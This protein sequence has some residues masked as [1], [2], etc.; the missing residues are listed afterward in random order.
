MTERQDR[1]AQAREEIA[2]RVANF[3]VT[4]E[5]FQ[6]EREEYFVTTMKNAR[7]ETSARGSGPRRFSFSAKPAFRPPVFSRPKANKKKPGGNAPGFS[8]YP[9]SD[10]ASSGA[11][12]MD[13]RNRHTARIGRPVVRGRNSHSPAHNTVR[14]AAAAPAAIAPAARPKAN[15]GPRPRAS[16]GAATVVAPTVAT[17]AKIRM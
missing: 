15:P 17:V 16:A 11:D 2:M 14:T 6:R 8:D 13:R 9:T 12:S 10:G 7:T 1:L 4:Q 3:K 5:K